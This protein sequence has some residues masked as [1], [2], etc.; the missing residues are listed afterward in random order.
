MKKK[1]K[2]ETG[3]TPHPGKDFF[4]EFWE[5]SWVY[6][7]TVVDALREPVV[8][9]DK[10]LQV[11]AANEA[12]Y[13]LFQVK[14]INTE[15]ELIYKLGNG[16]WN[17][18]KLRN[19]LEEILPEETF[20][21]GFEVKHRFPSV[22]EKTIVLNAQQIYSSNPKSGDLFP[23]L[24]MLAMDDITEMITI[25]NQFTDHTNKLEKTL[26]ARTNKLEAK[27]IK[28]DEKINALPKK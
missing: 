16:Q 3:K 7:T 27:L 5:E 9:L 23:K 2:F 19:L 22:G 1:E 17:I 10:D 24:I 15:G 4:A 6:I 28:L 11:L 25:A 14:K 13:T 8:I 26:S 20:F 18:P 12:F 21:K